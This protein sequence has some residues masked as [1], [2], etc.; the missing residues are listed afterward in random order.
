MTAKIVFKPGD[1]LDWAGT[2]RLEGVED[3]TGW[4]IAAQI[5]RLE[6]GGG[7]TPLASATCSWLDPVAGLLRVMVPAATTAGWPAPAELAIDIKLTSPDG[8][9]S[10]TETETFLT[11][12]RVPA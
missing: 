7:L 3:F 8:A 9:V 11:R 1:T 6:D 5:G 12:P 4:A 2:A 10:T